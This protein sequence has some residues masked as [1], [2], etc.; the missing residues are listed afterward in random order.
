MKYYTEGF[1][2]D[3]AVKAENIIVF[4]QPVPPYL[5]DDTKKVCL[6]LSDNDLEAK[7]LPCNDKMQCEVSISRLDMTTAVM[8]MLNHRKIRILTAD[9]NTKMFDEWRTI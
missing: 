4:F 9:D 1:I 2:A 6:L 7:L 5:I 8:L 3:I